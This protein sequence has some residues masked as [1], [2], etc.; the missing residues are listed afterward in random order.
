MSILNQLEM[1]VIGGELINAEEAFLL[2][3]FNDKEK[4]YQAANRIRE[5]F[6]GNHIDLCTI[7]NA[8]SGKC[9]EDC[10]WCSQS[11]KY[12]T[13]IETYGLIDFNDAYSQAMHNEKAGAHKFSLVTSGRTI[14]NSN[15]DQLCSIYKKVGKESKLELCASM[16]LLDREKL[17]KLIDSGVKNYHCNIETAPSFFP[18]LCST[19]TLEEKIS[20]LKTARELGLHLCCGGIIGMG[21]TL[22]QRIEM[23]ITLQNLGVESIP[24][25][26]LNPIP[27]TPLEN[28]KPL[29]DE[30]ILTTIALFRF[31]NPKALIR[32]AGGRMLILH[33]QDE[34]LKAGINAAL[35]G[36]LL[37]TVGVSMKDDVQYFKESGFVC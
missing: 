16:G 34:A 23:G 26:I 22:E 19:H 17:Q 1:K 28:Q 7:V 14:S 25:N 35:I 3:Q 37:T 21:E 33:I 9:S 4:L 30:E 11:N 6:C 15:L 27:R 29:S 13:G 5:F 18:K 10:K 8:K 36:D 31:L 32:F 12:K 2:V 24:L 20:T